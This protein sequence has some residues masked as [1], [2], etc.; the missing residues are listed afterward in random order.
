MSGRPRVSHKT[1]DGIE[2]KQCFRCKSWF[3]L[4][5]FGNHEKS[6]DK[7]RVVCK[8]CESEEGKLYHAKN[9][10]KKAAYRLV[11]KE[12]I[13]KRDAIYYQRN[14]QVCL[15]A[16]KLWR[17]NNQEKVRA[18]KRA[19]SK[20]R[21]STS[22]GYLS[23]NIS[24]AIGKA[25][26]GD[27]AGRHWE[28]LVGYSLKQLYR[29]LKKTIPKGYTWQDYLDGKLH[30]DH[31]TPVSVFNFEEPEDTDFQRCFALKNLQLLPARE[32]IIKSN[33]LEGHFQPSFRF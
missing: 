7:L 1:I 13:K 14:K 9:K 4:R 27:K 12:K 26:K 29:R 16:K 28:N 8:N 24:K 23:H 21:R 19:E 17:E 33:K 5:G 18:Y 32:N 11:N 31:K 22:K 25:L 6:W 3:P 30:I 15:K 2:H 10:G 20:K